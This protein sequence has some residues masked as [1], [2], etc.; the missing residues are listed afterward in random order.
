MNSI[1][2]A[3]LNDINGGIQEEIHLSAQLLV[4]E[5]QHITLLAAELAER[6]D[7][8]EDNVFMAMKHR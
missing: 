7:Q 6:V 4:E 2:Q 1:S 3:R 5:L 8:F